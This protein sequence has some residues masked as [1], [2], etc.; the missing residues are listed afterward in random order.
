MKNQTTLANSNRRWLKGAILT[1]CVLALGSV[2]ET[3]ADPVSLGDASGFTVLGMGTSTNV[4]I[5]GGNGVHGTVGATG[6]IALDNP[7]N[8]FGDVILGPNGSFKSTAQ[9]AVTSTQNAALIAQAAA[10]ARAA[11][12]FAAGL[13]AT[14]SLTSLQFSHSSQTINGTA[15]LNVLNLSSVNLD[16]DTLILSAPAGGSFVLNVTGDFVLNT[17][18]I[19]LAG[20]LTSNDVLINVIGAGSNVAFT[21]GGNSS[22]V[23]GTILATDRDIQLSPGMVN[24]R[25]IGG[26]NQITLVSGSEVNGPPVPEP[27]TM[28]LLGTGLA[29]I[30]A[31][32]RRRRKQLKD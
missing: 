13:A 3:K 24:G 12:T 2:A 4:S 21:G 15:G 19:T 18:S 6:Q 26:G 31:K 23:F 14:N 1:V 9:L 27:T 25:I 22:V 5:N 28:L 16:H 20:G 32:L 11:S 7:S 30:A 8:I 17:G 10:D 29:G